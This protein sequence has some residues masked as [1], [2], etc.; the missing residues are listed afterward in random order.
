MNKLFTTFLLMVFPFISYAQELNITIGPITETKDD[1]ENVGQVKDKIYTIMTNDKGTEKSLIIY[2]QNLN[3]QKESQF[4][5]KKVD[6]IGVINSK[7]DYFQSL[8]FKNSIL[9]I[10]STFETKSKSKLLLV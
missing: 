1:I 7:F 2:D 10:F 8:F 4:Y 9:H 3:L 6:G 5:S